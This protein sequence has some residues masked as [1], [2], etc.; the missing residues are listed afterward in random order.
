M[1]YVGW[2]QPG[3]RCSGQAPSHAG[4]RGD[5]RVG[6]AG[7]GADPGRQGRAGRCQCGRHQGGP[8]RRGDGRHPGARDDGGGW[9]EAARLPRL[10]YALQRHV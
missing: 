10:W 2:H 3:Q 4:G 7:A 1:C 8:G 6:R 5:H 9:A